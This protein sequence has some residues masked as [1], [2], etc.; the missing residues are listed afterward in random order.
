[1]N[2]RSFQSTQVVWMFIRVLCA[3]HV[4][5]R[6]SQGRQW[7]FSEPCPKEKQCAFAVVEI[8]SG[9]PRGTIAR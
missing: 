7:T 8:D 6:V 1:L 3:L 4:R 9:V 2:F 5:S